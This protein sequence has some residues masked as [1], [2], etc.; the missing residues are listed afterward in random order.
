LVEPVEATRVRPLIVFV[1][2][3][4]AAFICLVGLKLQWVAV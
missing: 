3:L 1:V 2:G 4:A